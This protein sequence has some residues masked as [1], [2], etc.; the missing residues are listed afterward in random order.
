MPHLPNILL[1]LSLT[2][3]SSC[4]MV[5]TVYD[6]SGNEVVEREGGER[7]L[8][9]Y[10]ASTF[11][12]DV[13]R[14]KNE[15]GVPESSSNK[16]SRYQRDLDAARR[17]TTTYQ[18]GSFS[19]T[20]SFSGGR[21]SYSDA[22]RSF[23][24]GTPYSGTFSSSDYNTDLRPA[25]MSDTRGVFCRDETY[26]VSSADR[27]EADGQAHDTFATSSTFATDYSDISRDTASGYYESRKNKFGKPRI[28]S[29]REYYRRTIQE[30]RSMLGRDEEPEE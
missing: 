2:V 4:Q 13:T 19:G 27:Y 26:G 11:D 15:D 5:R 30:T 29:H 9:D 18:T 6:E 16:V 1:L 28:I 3:L 25:F 22:G 10:M 24:T 7:S 8:E 14:K 17:D 21:Q 20:H 12:K 23:D